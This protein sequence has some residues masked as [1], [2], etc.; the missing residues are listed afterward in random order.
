MKQDLKMKLGDR[1]ILMSYIEYL[2]NLTKSKKKDSKSQ[3]KKRRGSLS[4]KKKK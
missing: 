2:N 1:K 4:I 3:K